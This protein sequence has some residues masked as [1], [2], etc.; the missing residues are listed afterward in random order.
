MTDY[1]EIEFWRRPDI[2]VH[3]TSKTAEA[4]VISSGNRHFRIQGFAKDV[5]MALDEGRH[6]IRWIAAKLSLDST[7]DSLRRVADAVLRLHGY[8]LIWDMEVDQ[9]APAD[10]IAAKRATSIDF[11]W[12]RPLLPA[13]VVEKLARPFVPVLRPAVMRFGFPAM[14]VSQFLFFCTHPAFLHPQYYT[15]RF[16]VVAFGALV[17]LNYLALF[18]HELGHAAACLAAGGKNGNIGACLYIMFPGLYTDVTD[19]WK[20][21]SNRRLIVDAGGVYF[22]LLVATLSLAAYLAFHDPVAGVLAC[23]CDLTAIV[24]LNP[25]LRMDGYWILGDFLEMPHLMEL[26]KAVTTALLSRLFG[27]PVALPSIPKTT[28]WSVQ[29]YYAYYCFFLATILYFAF[30]SSVQGLPYVYHHYPLIAR[31]AVEQLRLSPLSWGAARDLLS[32]LVATASIAGLLVVCFRLSRV[33]LQQVA[34]V[35]NACSGGGVSLSG[36]IRPNGESARASRHG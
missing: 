4:V 6:D 7:E 28:R 11:V 16:S 25:I 15:S 32:L 22:S 27:R 36:G 21:P 5:L 30:L 24:N 13:R 18:L 26:N 10:K 17:A 9:P 19:S 1:L 20:L 31:V 8:G 2:Q 12:K 29:I 35:R 3:E 14:A 23:L 34:M 33:L